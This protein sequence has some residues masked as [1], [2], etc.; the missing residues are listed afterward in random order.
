MPYCLKDYKDLFLPKCAGCKKCIE[1]S[2]VGALGKKWHEDC[3]TCRK[4]KCKF[5]GDFYVLNDEPYCKQHFHEL[6]GSCCGMCTL[7]VEGQCVALQNGKKIH[8]DCFKCPKCDK[9][10]ESSFYEVEGKYYCPNDGPKVAAE[11]KRK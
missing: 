5:E 1:V 8:P 10:I 7:P 6:N 3:F 9:K 4:C 2:V 11:A